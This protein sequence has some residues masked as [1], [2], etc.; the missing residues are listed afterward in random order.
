MA[1]GHMIDV[2]EKVLKHIYITTGIKMEMVRLV[3]IATTRS[4]LLRLL[5]EDQ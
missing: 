1:V 4:K 3:R 5:V 2:I